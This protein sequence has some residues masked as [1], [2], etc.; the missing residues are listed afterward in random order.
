MI[1]AAQFA[2][3]CNLSNTT[4]ACC[5]ENSSLLPSKRDS[6]IPSQCYP[7]PGINNTPRDN[8][9]TRHTVNQALGT[10]TAECTS[11][12]HTR[13]PVIFLTRNAQCFLS[14]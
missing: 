6:E 9:R 4:Y 11:P 8:L 1:P 5:Y 2:C 13:K 10:F 14:V 3:Y 12:C 7:P